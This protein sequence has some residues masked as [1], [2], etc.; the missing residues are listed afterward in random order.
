MI[1]VQEQQ[2]AIN[3]TDTA[4]QW[5]NTAPTSTHFTVGGNTIIFKL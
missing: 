1:V 2:Q 3:A 5:G 4:V